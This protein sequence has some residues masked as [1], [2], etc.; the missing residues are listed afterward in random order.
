[1]EINVVNDFVNAINKA[2]IDKICDLISEDYIFIDSHDNRAVGIDNMRDGWTSYFTLFP[3]YKIEIN[4]TIQKDSM[5]CLFGYASGTY[6]NLSNE[7]N[8]N[9]WRIPAA[10]TAIVKDGKIK[11]WQV[12]TDNMKVMEIINRNK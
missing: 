8:S 9:F 4:E 7:E 12:Y 6:L 2:N 5:I 11:Q 3:D 1:M 10:W